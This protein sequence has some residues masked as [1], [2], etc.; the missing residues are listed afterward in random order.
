[1]TPIRRAFIA[2]LDVAL[3]DAVLDQHVALAG[4]A[5]V[6]HIQRAAPVGN[7]AVVQHRHA[8]GRHAL[9]DAAAEGA[10]ALAVEVAL[11]PVA[12]RFVQQDAGPARAQH[13]GHLAGRRRARLQVGQR[14]T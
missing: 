1:L 14:G 3:E 12:D 4:V 6:V 11:Q 9:A 8:L 13:H 7:G 10:R 2:V 5:L